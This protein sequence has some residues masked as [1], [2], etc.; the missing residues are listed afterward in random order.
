MKILKKLGALVLAVC[1]C[2]FDVT[3]VANAYV[4]NDYFAYQKGE[5]MYREDVITKGK[6]HLTART[7][8]WATQY[9]IVKMTKNKI[10]LRPQKGY[11][12]SEDPYFK[13]V[14][15]TYPL[16]SKCKFYYVDSGFPLRYIQAS[17][18]KYKKVSKKG[19]SKW[20]SDKGFKVRL[21][22]IEKAQGKYYTSGYFGDIYLKNGKV[23]AVVTNGGD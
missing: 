3:E 1:I 11:Y 18:L 14:T 8:K 12:E 15:L 21:E 5:K 9:Q 6:T 4:Y 22:Y 2:V 13:K 23:V 10:T 20:M 17:V 19:V 7:K 16:S